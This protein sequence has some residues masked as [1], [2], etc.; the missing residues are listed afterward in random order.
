MD[1]ITYIVC[2]NEDL[3]RIGLTALLHEQRNSPS[4]QVAADKNELKKFVEKN[5]ESLVILSFE[6]F[7]FENLDEIKKIADAHSNI[8]WLFIS[9][10]VISSFFIQLT[11]VLPQAN[12]VLKTNPKTDILF[13]ILTTEEGKQYYCSEAL[14]LILEKNINKRSNTNPIV[15]LTPTEKEIAQ[16]I[17]LGKSVKE[18]AAERCLSFH[19][20]NT[21]KKNIFRKMEVR[22]VHDLTKLAIKYDLVNLIE[23]Y[24]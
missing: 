3:T 9:Q 23:Y 4:I 7:D 20:V 1:E 12:F 17:A 13:A 19:T 15:L 6:T 11:S 14:D 24:I 2:D 16:L 18:I 5:G 21:H 22:T 8:R 10:H